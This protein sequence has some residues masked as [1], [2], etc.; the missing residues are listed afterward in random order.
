MQLVKHP[1]GQL[2]TV[3]DSTRLSRWAMAAALLLAAVAGYEA[4]QHHIGSDRFIGA[5]GGGATF[6]LMALVLYERT[7]F[8][9]DP[10]RRRVHWSQRWMWRQHRGEIAFSDIR[11][12]D[13][14]IALGSD[15][16]AP[17]WRIVLRTADAPLPLSAGYRPDPDD[18]DLE[19]VALI[20]AI[21]QPS[22]DAASASDAPAIPPAI[23]ELARAG[24]TIEAI[25]RLRI[26]RG[27]SLTEA[28]RIVD[29]LHA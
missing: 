13:R 25:K 16:V 15:S 11:R 1:D 22:D 9:F 27:M 3:Q 20:N 8:V 18:A 21:L 6:A 19:I 29:S 10:R 26:E 28:K 5:L 12:A 24:K 17:S 2:E 7:R 4:L 14:E 23:A